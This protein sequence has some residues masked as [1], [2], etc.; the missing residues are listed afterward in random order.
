[1]DPDVVLFLLNQLLPDVRTY[2]AHWNSRTVRP[3][4]LLPKDCTDSLS[5]ITAMTSDD[6]F[7][8]W[9][10][11]AYYEEQILLDEEKV[12]PKC[13]GEVSVYAGVDAGQRA[14]PDDA[15][16]FGIG[17][18][19]MWWGTCLG[20][21]NTSKRLS[22]PVVGFDLLRSFLG[23][24]PILM[25]HPRYVAE[26]AATLAPQPG[27]L[28]FQDSSGNPCCRFRWWKTRPLGKDLDES[29]PQ[30]SGCD[31]IVSPDCWEVIEALSSPPLLFETKVSRKDRAATAR[32]S[33]EMAKARKQA[34][35][36]K[37]QT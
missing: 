13:T 32:P 12:L 1:M 34:R 33:R 14:K 27:P 30:L 20:I 7:A 35:L 9:T 8:G 4:M 28:L 10:R 23:S 29:T 16:P 19:R 21:T 25:P 22:G 15:L 5:Q 31:L 3:P 17:D 26:F 11:L 24:Y 18:I 37:R 36:R 6:E 2:A